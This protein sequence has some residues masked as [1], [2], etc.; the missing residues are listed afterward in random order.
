MKMN[1]I[2][3]TSYFTFHINLFKYIITINIINYF[4]NYIITN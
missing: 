2:E 1:E 3:E 4:I